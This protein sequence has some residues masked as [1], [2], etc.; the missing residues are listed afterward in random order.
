[1]MVLRATRWWVIVAM[2]SAGSVRAQTFDLEQFDQIF[3]PRLKLD[4]R[5]TP[6]LAFRDEPGHYEDRTATGVI[7]FPVYK[8]W[9]AGVNF[10]SKNEG[11]QEVLKNAIQIRAAQVMGNAR[12]GQRQLVMDGGTRVLH[13]ASL[14]ALG[15]SLTR[16]YRIL[17]LGANANVS[18]EEGTLDKAVPRFTGI[19]GKMRVKGLRKQFF[20]GLAA[21]VSDGLNL[22]VPFI[23]G[24]APIG[25]RWSFQ[26]VLPLQ[27][28]FGF[29]ASK[30]TRL[31]FGVGADGYRSGFLQGDER[32]N[33]N[34]TALR[35]FANVRHRLT[36]RYQLRVEASAPL[37][38][39]LRLPD[40]DG[41]IQHHAIVPGVQVSAGV[42]IYFGGSTLE[43]LLDD[44]L[45]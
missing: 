6:R 27:V 41:D 16:N 10:D 8:R 14:G 1:M 23:G 11:L 32:V 22:P 33:M 17:Y 3:R 28:G 24:T 4:A 37:A 42:N 43:R 5:W 45:K 40:P 39:G 36:K 19:I 35:V 25:D 30:D 26:Y 31:L 21:T 29:K 9:S 12:Y 7:T 38:H 2:L 44:V 15:I 18:E 34:Y 20:Y 13:S